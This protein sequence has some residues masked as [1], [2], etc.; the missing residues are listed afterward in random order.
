M[1]KLISAILTMLL[2]FSTASQTFAQVEFQGGAS[3]RIHDNLVTIAFDQLTHILPRE[4]G[5]I[6]VEL[7][8]MTRDMPTGTGY[9]LA[10]MDMVTLQKY[11][12]RGTINYG[13]H[14]HDIAFTT[15]YN[16]PPAGTYY[17]YLLAFEAPYLDKVIASIRMDGNPVF[18]SNAAGAG[19]LSRE[20]Y[21]LDPTD[22]MSNRL[23][24]TQTHVLQLATPGSGY[25]QITT[26]GVLD[27][28]GKLFLRQGNSLLLVTEDD[29]AGE[30]LNFALNAS[31][32]R[33]NYELHIS[34]YDGSGG[35]YTVISNFIPSDEVSA[36]TVSSRLTERAGGRFN[37]GIT[38]AS[39][40]VFAIGMTKDDSTYVSSTL[41]SEPVRIFGSIRP[42]PQHV[43]RFADI[44][45]VANVNGNF[46]MLNKDGRY[47]SWDTRVPNLVPYK[48]SVVLQADTFVDIHRG[49]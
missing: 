27:T 18:L 45:V 30:G 12:T 46:K 23:A 20:T 39:S 17:V 13:N 48:E 11:Y 34:T 10:S 5:T 49:G 24:T 3:Y 25:L 47:I 9:T 16:P 14:Y 40:A 7:A 4:T 36:I 1:S 37:E 43:G 42:E 33:G 32:I 26:S 35:D 2:L 22:V 41:L 44:F 21:S 8:A 6:H 15:Q 28:V 19:I 29:D 38:T 31:V